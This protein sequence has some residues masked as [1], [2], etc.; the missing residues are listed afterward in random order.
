MVAEGDPEPL[1]E[2]AVQLGIPAGI[3]E[4]GVAILKEDHARAEDAGFEL[5]KQL[6]PGDF[7]PF[8]Q[9]L[10]YLQK[11]RSKDFTNIANFLHVRPKF[12]LIFLLS[13][14]RRDKDMARMCY[15][16]IIKEILRKLVK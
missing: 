16:K 7:I 13:I 14:M 9:D 1:L 12:I 15:D 10:Y 2:I 4:I 8:F 3:F 11:G 5:A 6:L